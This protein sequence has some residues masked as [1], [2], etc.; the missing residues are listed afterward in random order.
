MLLLSLNNFILLSPFFTQNDYVYDRETGKVEKRKLKV[1]ED[2]NL[3]KGKRGRKSDSKRKQEAKMYMTGTKKFDTV[4]SEES[5][6]TGKKKKGTLK[7]KQSTLDIASLTRKKT[8]KKHIGEDVDM[9]SQP[10]PSTSGSGK[11][12]G[13]VS[14]SAE[15]DTNTVDI[16]DEKIVVAE[17]KIKSIDRKLVEAQK[18]V[19]ENV[20]EK[21]KN[22]DLVKTLRST[23]AEN[24]GLYQELKEQQSKENPEDIRKQ[25]EQGMAEARKMLD[26]KDKEHALIIR[27]KVCKLL[28]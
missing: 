7:K 13:I 9:E 17:K 5:N 26:E 21:A 3:I 23:I 2:G 15:S 4:P 6:V 20:L 8:K 12:P 18:L 27:Q 11:K 28:R 16:I 24:D 22:D 10:Q 14:T 1:D 25:L 19:S